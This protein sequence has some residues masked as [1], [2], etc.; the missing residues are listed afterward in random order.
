M[1][2]CD[3]CEGRTDVRPVNYNKLVA[4]SEHNH[5]DW[6]KDLCITC[7][8]EYADLMAR[9][10]ERVCITCRREYADLMARFQERIERGNTRGGGSETADLKR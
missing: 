4:I 9:F 8:R 1:R 10:Q 5:C 6:Q 3:R 7:R 2:I